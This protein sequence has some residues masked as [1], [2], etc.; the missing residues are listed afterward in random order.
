[1]AD[2]NTTNIA[3]FLDYENLAIGAT[4]HLHTTFDIGKLTDRLLA[5]GKIVVKRAYADWARFA[6]DK[7]A[8]HH[9]AVELI[10]VPQRS[11]GGKNSAD[12]RL[13]IDALELAYIRDHIDTFVIASGDSD[14]SPLVSKLRENGRLVIGV[15][16]KGSSSDLLI[17][18]CDEFIFY[19]DIVKTRASETKGTPSPK[20]ASVPTEQRAAFEL[21]VD[22]LLAL[23]KENTEILW[24][25]LVK[26]TILRKRPS[27]DETAHGFQSFSKL[28]VAAADA[29]LI[30][31]QRDKSR[32]TYVI[33]EVHATSLD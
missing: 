22:A 15:G 33:T 3:L 10:D 17:A 24:A 31:I 12:I 23:Q 19:Q 16:V 13:V 6:R 9:A 8:L 29:G 28:V 5:K 30:E 4:D 14:F 2:G 20:L 7:W 1:M 21:L 27:F 32:R 11:Q 18:N 26:Q 25:S